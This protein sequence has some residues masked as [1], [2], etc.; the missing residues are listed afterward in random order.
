MTTPLF[1]VGR[2]SKIENTQKSNREHFVPY[3]PAPRKR[4]G[5]HAVSFVQ[6]FYGTSYQE[7]MEL[8]L[9][10]ELGKAYPA[11]QPKREEQPRPFAVRPDKP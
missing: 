2:L 11:A 1:L 9:G 10:K 3:L 7:A 8:L 6:H 4:R 5:G